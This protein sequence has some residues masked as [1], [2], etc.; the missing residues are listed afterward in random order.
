MSIELA[1]EILKRGDVVAIPTETVYGLAGRID[2]DL[3]LKKI[4][5]TKKRPFFDP[6]IVHVSNIDQAKKL[7]LDFPFA[8]EILTKKFWPGP[9]TLVLEKSEL[10]SDLITA[11]LT[12]VGIRMP[13]HPI[14]LSLIDKLNIPLAAPSANKFGKTSPTTSSHVKEEFLEEQ[15]YVLEGGEC[16]VGLESTVLFLEQSNNDKNVRF[17]ILRLGMISKQMIVDELISNQLN[18]VEIE[19]FE[20]NL[21]PGNMKHHY[22]PNTPLVIIPENESIENYIDTIKDKFSQFDISDSNFEFVIPKKFEKYEE[23]K[24][25]ANP[26]LAARELYSEMRRL[27][28]LQNDF[29]YFKLN[30]KHHA[31]EFAPILDKLKKA[32]SIIL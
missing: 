6:L 9:L 20:A 7:V 14:T 25:D 24:L 21:A 13:N 8:A 27:A 22:M 26:S 3:A 1:I 17:K 5:T 16:Q 4:F 10:V 15:V 30:T 32:A 12:R 29:I 2:S 11:G 31:Q 18:P 28:H 19:N 23:L